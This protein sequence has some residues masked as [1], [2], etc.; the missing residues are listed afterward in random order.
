MNFNANIKVLILLFQFHVNNIFNAS[1]RLHFQ[2]GSQ[3]LGFIVQKF[4]A[5]VDEYWLL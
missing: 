3:R 1:G 2:F 5:V 4:E